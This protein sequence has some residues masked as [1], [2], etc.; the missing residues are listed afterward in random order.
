MVGIEPLTM[1]RGS[2]GVTIANGAELSGFFSTTGLLLVSAATAERLRGNTEMA[3]KVHG[4]V[5]DGAAFV[6]IS[7]AD[8]LLEKHG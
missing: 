1:P 6:D 2:S 7:V 8:K 3:V 5:P 4:N